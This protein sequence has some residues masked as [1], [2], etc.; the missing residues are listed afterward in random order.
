V[1]L[2]AL[3]DYLNE[4][5]GALVDLG[6]VHGLA[7]RTRDARLAHEAALDL[8]RRKGNAVSAVRLER[9]VADHAPA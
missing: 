9:L 5:A 8:Y 1:S 7:G 2:A 4:H 6:H 3:T